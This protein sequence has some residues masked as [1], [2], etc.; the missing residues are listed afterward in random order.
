MSASSA[1][2]QAV[3]TMARSSRRLG[4]KIPG[5]S[6]KM[7]CAPSAIAIARS[8]MRVVCTLWETAATL[9]PTSA[10]ISVDLPELGG[11]MNATNPQRDCAV[12]V[13][14]ALGMILLKLRAAEHDGGSGLLGRALRAPGPLGGGKLG[15]LDPD[16]KLGIVVRTLALDLPVC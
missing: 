9:L 4:A 13:I 12:L 7:S 14:S 8:S 2:A 15:Q 3:A 11:P 16:A 5:V 6:T 10:L 1:P